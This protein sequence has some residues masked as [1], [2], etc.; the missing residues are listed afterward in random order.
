M[1]DIQTN[2]ISSSEVAIE[3]KYIK[4][5]TKLK[6]NAYNEEGQLIQNAYTPFTQE[7]VNELLRLGIEKIFYT[8]SEKKN[9]NDQ[10]TPL[11]EYLDKQLYTGP[12]VIDI[13]TQK[14][15]VS[16]IKKIAQLIKDKH[17]ITVDQAKSFVDMVLHDIQ[18]NMDEVINL[19]SLQLYDDHAYVHSINVGITS[20]VIAKELGKSENEIKEI[21]LGGFLHDIGKMAIPFEILSKKGKLEP[22][23]F[24]IMK[25]HP[26][27]GYE[28]V[29]DDPNLPKIVKDMILL[30][31]ERFDGMGYPL[32]FKENKIADAIYI[33]AVAE[34]YDALTT[35]HPYQDAV[36]LRE[37]KKR[38]LEASGK[39]FKKDIAM[40]FT[41]KMNIFIKE[42]DLPELNDYVLLNTDEIAKITEENK[43]NPSRPI[44]NI[45]I[46]HNKTL[47]KPLE[48]NLKLDLTREIIK[49]LTPDEIMKLNI[50]K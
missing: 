21:G 45:Y 3:V 18:N 19:L 50:P 23:E 34:T 30:H 8:L 46:Q 7:R 29:K 35:N 36:T 32:Q 12:R 44:I 4:P 22:H 15:G 38:I 49:I 9:I 10:I 31:H 16:A 47:K 40:F 25:K 33:I 48:I 2:Q 14:K 6:F 13:K 11:E 17:N 43:S 27:Y 42:N 28:M 41:K 1:D 20:M 37:C 5:G 39:Q 24:E 26:I